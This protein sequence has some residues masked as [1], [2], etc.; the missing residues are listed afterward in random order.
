MGKILYKYI[1]ESDASW[2]ELSRH[3]Y[4]IRQLVKEHIRRKIRKVIA[5]KSTKN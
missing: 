1:E 4:F 3:E 5:D 2:Y